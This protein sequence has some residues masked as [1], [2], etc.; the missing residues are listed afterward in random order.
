MFTISMMM[1]TRENAMAVNNVL[2]RYADIIMGRL[3]L[4]NP[5]RNIYTITVIADGPREKVNN[6]IEDLKKIKGVKLNALSL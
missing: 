4:P 1:R 6:L 5:E 3:G 2:H